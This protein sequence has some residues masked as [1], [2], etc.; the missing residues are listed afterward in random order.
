M[1]VGGGDRGVD[2]RT[3]STVA[4]TERWFVR[5]GLPH[6]IAEYTAT[7]NVL[8]R[9][10]PVLALAFLFS[11]TTTVSPARP[12][13]QTLLAVLG[14][15]LVLVGV[16]AAVNLARGRP[17]LARP[18]T[19][20]PVE[21]GV[22]LFVP[23]VIDLLVGTPEAAVATVLV[24]AAQL[25]AIY[26]ATSYGLLPMAVWSVVQV[27][28]RVDLARRLVV[29]TFP[30]LLL[31][32]T[33]LIFNATAWDSL[34]STSVLR[35]LLLLLLFLAVTLLTLYRGVTGEFERLPA[36]D[37]PEEIRDLAANSPVADIASTTELRPDAVPPLSPAERRNV[38]VMATFTTF[39]YVMGVTLGVLGFFLLFG[40]LA[41]P[42]DVIVELVGRP[43]TPLFTV[44]LSREPITVTG[45]LVRI[46]GF[47]SV[48]SALYFAVHAI[49]DRTFREGL[50]NHIAGRV[51]AALAVRA[52]YWNVRDRQQDSVDDAR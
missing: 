10:V 36:V 28:R 9:S 14:T 7:G 25:A 31:A 20:G 50:D 3:E 18:A 23:A 48:F 21:V 45:E 47:L 51:R 22:F 6:F 43:T 2:A 44:T 41:I 33:F 1:L 38:L 16:W 19:V 27:G 15:F 40:V 11:V 5:Q 17:P 39:V 35:Y 13:S 42:T 34:T 37:T 4:E 30:L 12:L 46:S 49:T 24:N 26:Y 8:P 52:V 29:R 32:V